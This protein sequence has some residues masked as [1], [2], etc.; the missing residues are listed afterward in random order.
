MT[1]KSSRWTA[2]GMRGM[3]SLV[4]WAHG[5]HLVEVEIRGVH[6][7]AFGRQRRKEGEREIQCA[8]RCRGTPGGSC[9]TRRRW[10][11]TRAASIEQ[12][13]GGSA[14]PSRSSPVEAMDAHA[15]G[16]AHQGNV[17][18]RGP[19]FEVFRGEAAPGRAGRRSSR[20]SRPDG[21]TSLRIS[22]YSIPKT[23]CPASVLSTSDSLDTFR[24]PFRNKWN[25]FEENVPFRT[26]KALTEKALREHSEEGSKRFEEQQ[27][28]GNVA[29]QER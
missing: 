15:V 16:E 12:P 10:N 4:Q 21:S 18:A 9:R 26:E 6:A 2:H 25:K 5:A 28:S 20:R 19:D 11:R 7:G 14:M 29:N 3:P 24:K 17:R 13:A 22:G 8:P 27:A 23:R 1:A